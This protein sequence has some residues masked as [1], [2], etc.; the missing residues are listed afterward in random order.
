MNQPNEITTP[1]PLYPNPSLPQLRPFPPLPR[2][3][4]IIVFVTNVN[5]QVMSLFNQK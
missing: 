3:R 2:A 1:P 5:C 4:R